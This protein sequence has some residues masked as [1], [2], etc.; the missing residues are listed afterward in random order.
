MLKEILVLLTALAFGFV[1]A[2][3][4]IG[5]GS[6]LVPTLIVFYGVDVK[7]AIP[8]GVAVAVATSLAATRV[9]LEKGVVNVK[10][11][12][13]LEIPS[14]AGAVL[15][16]IIYQV[17]E[18][19]ILKLIMGFVFPVIAIYML[20]SSRL[21]HRSREEDSIARKL[22]LSGE[23]YDENLERE[24]K[25]KVSHSPLLIA[26]S[27]LAGTL[28]AL[29][30]IGGGVIKMPL[31]CIVGGIPIKA[32]TATSSFMVGITAATSALVYFKEGFMEPSLTSIVIIGFILG[33]TM[34]AKTQVKVKSLWIRLIFAG[35]LLYASIRLILSS[36]GV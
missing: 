7:T 1:S 15:G 25:Y 12:L 4:G 20:L 32:A 30:G 27:F 8:I 29:L 22:E 5:G 3:A 18:V 16:S 13:L 21:K 6:L 26:G 10:L 2:I 24:V 19:K 35:I 36:I 9:Y 11:G 31:M 17:I 33:A 23:Y 34:G 28:S 14:T